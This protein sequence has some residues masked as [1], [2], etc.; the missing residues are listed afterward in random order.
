MKRKDIG[1]SREA[2][3]VVCEAQSQGS[4]V[5]HILLELWHEALIFHL[6][7]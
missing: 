5:R 1:F 3:Q 4:F 2:K 7:R 6:Q